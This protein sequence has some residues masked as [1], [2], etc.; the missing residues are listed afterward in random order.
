MESR[1]NN[2]LLSVPGAMN[3]MYALGKSASRSALPQ[4]T[5]NLVHL[6]ASQIN[7]CSVCVDI[8]SRDMKKA[9]E[10]DE[11][12]ILA[13]AWREAPYF[14]EAERAA[15]ALTE[16]MTRLA[17][18]TDPVSDAV[19]EEA[20]SHFDEESLASLIIQIAAINVWNR[21]N[22][23]TRQPAGEWTASITDSEDEAS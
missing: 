21:V 9:G 5:I 18:Q 13:S 14:T 23:A 12:I 19:F 7:G 11:R 15:L 16:A 6:R 10:P 20:A 8:H 1:M 17:D 2:P 4:S 22:V 3:A